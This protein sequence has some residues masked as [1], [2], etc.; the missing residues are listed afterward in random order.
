MALQNLSPTVKMVALAPRLLRD[1]N[2]QLGFGH[3]LSR[4]LPA[5]LFGHTAS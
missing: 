4:L 5:P 3:Y 2:T 1:R